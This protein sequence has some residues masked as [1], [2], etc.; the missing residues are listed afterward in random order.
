MSKQKVKDVFAFALLV[1]FLTV[2][3][4]G[5]YSLDRMHSSNIATAA[6]VVGI[7]GV[8]MSLFVAVPLILSNGEC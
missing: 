8:I 5:L 7:V 2:M 1:F 4:V 3:I 6:A